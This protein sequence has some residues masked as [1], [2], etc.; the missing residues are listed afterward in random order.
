MNQHNNESTLPDGEIDVQLV[1]TFE[2]YIIDEN[3]AL[4]SEGYEVNAWFR[5]DWKPLTEEDITQGLKLLAWSRTDLLKAIAGLDLEQLERRYP[6]ERWSIAG[7]LGHVGGAD[8]WYLDRLGLAFPRQQVP[9]EPF[10][11]LATIRGHLEKRL[12]ELAGSQQVIGVDG[13]FWSPRKLLRRAV[14]H[15]RDHTEHIHKLLMLSGIR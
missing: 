13:E 12:P 4:A 15:E 7:I 11:R 5:H 9:E 1:E 3:F 8:W 10:A 14:W 2:G 6:G